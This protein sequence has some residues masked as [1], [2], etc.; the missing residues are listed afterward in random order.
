VAELLPLYQ[1]SFQ[2]Q[3]NLEDLIFWYEFQL[4]RFILMVLEHQPENWGYLMVLIDPD[5]GNIYDT[6]TMPA[7]IFASL[8]KEE[9]L[10]EEVKA[11]I[12]RIKDDD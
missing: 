6:L 12:K 9:E 10:G 4:G 7:T 5:S 8:A 11:R 1:L 2:E 3:K